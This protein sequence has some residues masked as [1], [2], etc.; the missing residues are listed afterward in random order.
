MKTPQAR[1]LLID[2]TRCIGCRA[3]VDACK[4]SHELPGENTETELSATA[5][6]VLLDKGDDRY[7]RKL[8]MHCVDPSCVSV[9]PVAAFTKTAAGPV[10]YD[11]SRC[12]GCRYCMV[13][14]PFSVPRY[15]WSKAVPAVRKCDLCIA[16]LEQGLPT[17]CSEACPAE[18]T[19]GGTREELLAEAHRR[20]RENPGAY[21][22]EVYG[23][24]EAGGTSVLFLSPVSFEELGFK[25][26]LGAQPLPELTWAALEKIPGV[27]S[28]GGAALMAIWWITHRREEVALAEAGVGER[29]EMPI[30]VDGT[31]G[32]Q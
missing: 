4:T 24:T 2:I 16:R 5:Y 25:A 3:C 20:I 13:A 29:A 15:E 22:P 19:V 28:I 23:E 18:A 11:Q 32:R 7:V 31:G 10:T 9:C 14:C 30:T 21:Y 8:C 17:A 1:A 26:G 6:T 12:L 27:V